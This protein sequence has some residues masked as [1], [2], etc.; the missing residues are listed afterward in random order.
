MENDT[1]NPICAAALSVAGELD[2]HVF[3]FSS[4]ISDA[5]FGKLVREVAKAQKG[6]DRKNAI[7]ILT[8]HGGLANSAYQIGRLLQSVYDKFYLFAPGYCKSAGTIVALGAHYIF[9]DTFSELGPL[10]VQVPDKDEIGARKS[11]LISRYAFE[12]LSNELF[13]LFSHNMLNIKIASRN[14][15]SF[16]LAADI[17]ARM[18]AQVMSEIFAQISPDVVASNYRDLMV[19]R[20]YGERL[21][22]VAQNAKSDTV[23]HLVE[24]YPSHD[25]VI[26]KDEASEL[27][28]NVFVPTPSIYSLIGLLGQI[29]YDEQET[30]FVA[31]LSLED[32]NDEQL[33][34]EEPEAPKKHGM[35]KRRKPD[36]DRDTEQKAKSG[37]SSSDPDHTDHE[38]GGHES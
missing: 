9:M 24:D 34:K 15:I 36:R 30:G 2:A 8:T 33:E 25:Y 38:A 17:S 16:R 18:S 7:L 4:E 35:G 22:A 14:A 23:R 27:F 37:S 21:A 6:S 19:A 11:G 32:A 13:D 10:D 5:S 31:F 12:S 1:D 20:R 3:C 28:N 26:D 29:V